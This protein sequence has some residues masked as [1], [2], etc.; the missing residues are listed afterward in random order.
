MRPKPVSYRAAALAAEAL[1]RGS[2]QSPGLLPSECQCIGAAFRTELGVATIFGSDAKASSLVESDEAS[3]T[4]ALDRLSAIST[5]HLGWSVTRGLLVM[6]VRPGAQDN[7]IGFTTTCQGERLAKYSLPGCKA[8]VARGDGIVY[9]NGTNLQ[10]GS[11]GQAGIGAGSDSKW[12]AVAFGSVKFEKGD[13]V[14]VVIDMND[15]TRPG[16]VAIASSVGLENGAGPFVLAADVPPGTIVRPVI[17]GGQAKCNVQVVELVRDDPIA[18][19]EAVAAVARQ[20]FAGLLSGDKETASLSA[21]G[22]SLII[23]DKAS[24]P[25]L[26]V[27]SIEADSV[28]ALG[29]MP[30]AFGR[31]LFAGTMAEEIRAKSAEEV[32]AAP[33]AG[34]D[35]SAMCP[36]EASND[37]N[38][39]IHRSQV[40]APVVAQMRFLPGEA[41]VASVNLTQL[42][43]GGSV[44]ECVTLGD[45]P[46]GETLMIGVRLPC[47][48]LS[49]LRFCDGNVVSG[50]PHEVLR[51]QAST[52]SH[53]VADLLPPR[54]REGSAAR[55]VRLAT[56]RSRALDT[57]ATD[58]P[59]QVGIWVDGNFASVLGE[60]DVGENYQYVAVF[61]SRATNSVERRSG[62]VE[63]SEEAIAD[64]LLSVPAPGKPRIYLTGFATGTP[65]RSMRDFATEAKI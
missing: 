26:P 18:R 17:Y 52:T 24:A 60:V 37:S 50:A 11:S 49:V 42:V 59:L 46:A 39:S 3:A 13:V 23:T 30:T 57:T 41:S 6:V 20:R 5:S 44:L 2:L 45:R 31:D 7:A 19:I 63:L 51:A 32:R 9:A 1:V 36:P 48:N 62:A 40:L 14:A 54:V 56:L 35:A 10:G 53:S 33:T 4:F 47:G 27:M 43:R 64:E 55:Q 25:V 8:T 21:A 15:G 16:S 12:E 38:T 29:S 34:D 28:L 65:N 22:S 58:G 61:G